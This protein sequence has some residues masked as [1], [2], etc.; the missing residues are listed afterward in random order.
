MA[1]SLAPGN[2]AI[3]P[4]LGPNAGKVHTTNERI[5]PT[6]RPTPPPN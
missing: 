1:G 6:T 3:T 2:Y 5:E 4:V